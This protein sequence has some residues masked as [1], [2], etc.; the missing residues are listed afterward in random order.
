MKILLLCN[1]GMSTSLLVRKMEE[2]AVKQGMTEVEIIARSIM[3]LNKLIDKYDVIMIGPQV[4]YKE[5]MVAEACETHSKKYTV[6]TPMIYGMVD[7]K[8]ALELALETLNK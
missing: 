8:K 1:E 3:E 5:K 2:E 4:K 7:G 6:I